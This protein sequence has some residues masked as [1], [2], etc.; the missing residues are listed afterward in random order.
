MRSVESAGLPPHV[1]GTVLGRPIGHGSRGPV[2]SAVGDDGTRLAVSV[3][4]VHSSNE[5]RLRRRWCLLRDRPHSHVAAVRRIVPM[6]PDRCAVLSD[7][8]D[9][10]TLAQVVAARGALPP[11]ELATLLDGV[12]HALGHLHESGVVH[13]D[14]SPSNVLVDDRGRPVLIDLVGDPSTEAG[15]PG[16]VA[17]ERS[18]DDEPAPSADVWSL[19]RVVL[20]AGAD[21]DPRWA[22]LLAPGLHESPGRR[23]GARDLAAGAPALGPRRP[24]V[25]PT[26]NQLLGVSSADRGTTEP[27]VR[28]DPGRAEARSSATPAAEE[29]E[30]RSS[31]AWRGPAMVRRVSTRVRRGV[32]AGCAGAAVIAGTVMVMSARSPG[33]DGYEPMTAAQAESVLADLLARRDDGLNRAV[34]DT[35]DYAAAGSSM[36]LSDVVL[37]ERLVGQGIELR[38]LSTHV[39]SLEGVEPAGEHGGVRVR[40]MV[41]QAAHQQVSTDGTEEIPELPPSCLDFRL[42]PDGS[43]QEWRLSEARPC[44]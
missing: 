35:T 34:S 43:G 3:V 24:I 21:A 9:G 40:A 17:P 2:W 11:E 36:A 27:T 26:P 38:G 4:A 42:E 16:F 37:V 18:R 8:V 22:R 33:E 7:R 15:T 25:V 32:V 13:G 6:A 28:R 30:G 19:A 23:P 14:V 31:A 44:E 39:T 12:G 10:I 41:S 29:D 1:P 20:W 5:T